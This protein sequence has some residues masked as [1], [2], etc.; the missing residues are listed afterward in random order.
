LPEWR[1]GIVKLVELP[2]I[3]CLLG[4]VANAL[5]DA[6][7]LAFF[8]IPPPPFITVRLSLD[9]FQSPF[10]ELGREP[11]KLKLGSAGLGMLLV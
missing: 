4:R 2:P 9:A 8:M 10:L 6:F 3:A 1:S 11:S 5:I 7:A